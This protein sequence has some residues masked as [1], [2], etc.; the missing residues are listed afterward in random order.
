M[1][2]MALH[3]IQ[4]MTAGNY[5]HNIQWYKNKTWT[6]DFEN[7]HIF[8]SIGIN[9]KRYV[10]RQ[11]NYIGAIDNL[12]WELR[13]VI[14]KE[15]LRYA[16]K[17]CILNLSFLN[18]YDAAFLEEV[19]IALRGFK[20]KIV[21]IS[22]SN[23]A[24]AQVVLEEVDISEV[25]TLTVKGCDL[26]RLP[27]RWQNAECLTKLDVSWNEGIDLFGAISTKN[28]KYI[29]VLGC[30]LTEI[31]FWVLQQNCLEIFFA[32]WNPG[33]FNNDRLTESYFPRLKKFDAR[34]CALVYIPWFIRNAEFLESLELSYNDQLV[35]DDASECRSDFLGMVGVGSC[36][37]TVIPAWLCAKRMLQVVRISNNPIQS[38]GILASRS[39]N[40]IQGKTYP[41]QGQ[42]SSYQ[43]SKIVPQFLY[44][45]KDPMVMQVPAAFYSY[46]QLGRPIMCCYSDSQLAGNF[47]NS[48]E[49][50][51]YS[52]HYSRNYQG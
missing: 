9:Q 47:P 32:A 17:R 25:E 46:D 6:T 28:L 35:F 20:A 41:Y 27:A 48:S 45:Q 3:S 16:A 8:K 33:L 31:P 24:L 23:P 49:F 30:K 29:N 7:E 2:G 50:G 18:W 14:L 38:L 37:L 26:K 11:V 15:Q 40:I 12:M 21:L 52:Q 43:N 22:W 13:Y 19:R 39:V 51:Y 4:A 5:E 34:G 10:N 44:M 42:D 1:Q 36:G